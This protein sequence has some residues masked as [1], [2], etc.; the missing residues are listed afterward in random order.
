MSNLDGFTHEGL[1]TALDI[2]DN[3]KTGEPMC[4]PGDENSIL[5]P[6]NLLNHHLDLQ[7]IEDPIVLAMMASRDPK[8][9]WP[10]RRRRG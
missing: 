3:Y 9:R 4:V 5:V 10:L 7:A 2:K 1:K 6:E 8:R